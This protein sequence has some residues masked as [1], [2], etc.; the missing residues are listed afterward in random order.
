MCPADACRMLE[1]MSGAAET[2]R[3]HGLGGFEETVKDFWASRPR[4]PASGRKIAGVAAGIGNRYGIDPVIVR[5]AFVAATVF[6]GIGI[7]ADLLCWLLFPGGDDQVSPIEALFG[8]GRS[9]M[10]RGLTICLLIVVF[11][12]SSW[13][14]TNGW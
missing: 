2:P 9:S 13:V 6:G 10:S 5:V 4:R 12:L 3:P 14:F 1:A 8:R 7:P 11:P